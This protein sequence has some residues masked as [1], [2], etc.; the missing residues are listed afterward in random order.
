MALLFDAVTYVVAALALLT[1]RSDDRAAGGSTPSLRA[2]VRDI[3]TGLA[4]AFDSAA[5][6]PL[7]FQSAWLNTFLQVVVVVMPIYALRVLGLGPALFGVVLASGS[8][9]SLLG[10]I[11]A[12]RLG[13]R[14][15]VARALVA[16][17]A[18][19]CGSH[20]ALPFAPH[21]TVPA[22]LTLAAAYGVYGFGLAIFN[23]HSLTVRVCATPPEVLGRV[24]A[25]YRLVTW[26][27]MPVGALCGGLV[28]GALGARATLAIVAVALTAGAGAFATS[29]R[30]RGSHGWA[31]G[32]GGVVPA[33]GPGAGGA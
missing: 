6:R 23:V 8:V 11:A 24:V 18:L 21:A 15:G 16:G 26:G 13:D 27:G 20:L 31:V 3:R 33:G 9:G 32:R 4:S 19:T 10:C 2:F 25:S 17:M 22:A 1:I 28:A 14:Y 5:L 29:L 12:G 7:M 30:A